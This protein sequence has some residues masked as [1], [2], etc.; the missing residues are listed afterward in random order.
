LETHVPE[1]ST[2]DRRLATCSQYEYQTR[3]VPILTLT[4]I[5][6]QYGGERPIDFLKIDVEGWELQ[7][8]TGFDLQRYRPAIIAIEATAPQTRI[9]CAANWEHLL[10]K[11]GYSSVYFDGLNKFYVANEKA[12]LKKHFALPPN[13]FDEFKT[14]HLIKVESRLAETQARLAQ[15]QIL[16]DEAQTKLART[17]ILLDESQAKLAHTQILLDES[18]S[19]LARKVLRSSKAALHHLFAP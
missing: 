12:A 8:L 2:F 17:H 5:L 16:L 6:D 19:S 14:E 7:V 18:R 4:E 13:I 9:E 3:T 1:L 10:D 15:T 11:G